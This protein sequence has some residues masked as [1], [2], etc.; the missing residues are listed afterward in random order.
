MFKVENIKTKDILDNQIIASKKKTYIE[1][2]EAFMDL[3]ASKK[4]YDNRYTASSRAGIIDS[5][6]QEESKTFALWMDNCYLEAYKMLN[7]I[8]IDTN[9]DKYISSSIK[10]L[11]KLI[12]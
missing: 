4:K 6:F 8:N 3:Q 11:P 9:I 2:I 12:W 7:S 10:K 1:A 5:P